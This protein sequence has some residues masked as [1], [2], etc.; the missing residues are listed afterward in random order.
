SDDVKQALADMGYT[1]PAPVQ[2]A[3][4][5]PA[6][7]GLDLV[8][9]ARTG[10]GKT[11]SFGIPLVDQLVK[12][13][14]R[15]AQALVLTPTRELALQVFREIERIG[16]KR[17]IRPIA[18]YGGAPMQ[19][20]I[21]GIRDG[22]QI[23][24]GTPGRVLDHL[25]RG[26]LPAK[27][28]RILVLDESDE[29]LSMGFERELH[30]IIEFLP[31]ERQTLLF[32]A[33]LP[34]EIVR[35][36][37]SRLRDPQFI[38]LS[39]DHVGALDV[40]HF[41]YLVM[42]DKTSALIRVLEVEDPE[43]SL[44]FCNTRDDT[45]RVA[46][47]LTRA[48]FDADWLNGDLPQNEREKVM[49]RSK[50]GKLRFLVA[51]DVAAR[52]I[53]IS[54]LTHVINFDF[55][56]TSESYVHRTGRTG[57]MGRT[58]TAISLITPHDIGSLYYLRLAY[59]IRPI[60]KQ[61]PTEGEL[62]TRAQTDLI[63]IL[64]QAFADH[65]PHPDDLS[66]ARRL[67]SHDRCE[68]VIA[69][70]LRGH[71]GDRPKAQEEAAAARR[72]RLPRPV[73]NESEEPLPV[74]PPPPPPPLPRAD[75][76]DDG[77]GLRERRR[78]TRS[79]QRDDLVAQPQRAPLDESAPLLPA[80]N[81]Q[82]VAQE[83]ALSK[84][85]PSSE[86]P[87]DI[88]L[89]EKLMAPE[90]DVDPAPPSLDFDDRAAPTLELPRRA[91]R[92]E[93]AVRARDEQLDDPL[94][95]YE[96]SP[97]TEADLELART[98]K[99]KAVRRGHAAL[100]DWEPPEEDNDDQPI[101]AASRNDAAPNSYF[102]DQDYAEIFVNVGRRD[103]VRAGDFMRVLAEAPG[104]SRDDIGRIRIRDRHTFVLV[105]RDALDDALDGLQGQA[106]GNRVVNAEVARA[107]D[108]GGDY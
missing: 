20:Q 21:D 26:S 42:T 60:E 9:Q 65:E 66:L 74:V 53:D 70:L 75:T 63:Q 81:E 38:Y 58:G 19:R 45:E 49:G 24:V 57:R 31:Q 25:R 77:P 102:D 72:A 79:R 89:D 23:V 67:L 30:A 105:R 35:V 40:M 39:G 48:G 34:P 90:P 6:I 18:V 44:I 101:F 28:L 61:L 17:G 108:S 5:D 14:S 100:A 37:S 103:G 12:R 7:R 51:T 55:P 83:P 16:A 98:E 69:G 97:L 59:K 36:A 94:P 92:P 80:R 2:H 8:V 27:D 99:A 82:F 11:A 76:D 33:T 4:Y 46:A 10:T 78:A 41:V 62:Q 3:V 95:R 32:S 106:F 84:R 73:V 64:V 47:I 91:P 15:T 1:H 56:D 22:A 93:R 85:T 107:R 88:G 71:L 43:S 86:P 13:S 52:G 68:H 96:T 104:V 87:A 50:A 29:M 54:H